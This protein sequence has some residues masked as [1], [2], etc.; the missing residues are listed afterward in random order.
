M[1]ALP[2]RYLGAKPWIDALGVLP[3]WR[4]RG[5]GASLLRTAFAEF[6]RRRNA[7]VTLNVDAQNETGATV[8]YERVGMRPTRR[9]DIYEKCLQ[10]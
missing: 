5:I 4:G 2:G 10:R 8:L 3:A 6:R 1:G 7:T 9:W